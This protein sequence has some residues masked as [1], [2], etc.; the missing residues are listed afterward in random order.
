MQRE[1]P[2]ADAAQSPVDGFLDE[3][4][5]IG[6]GILYK[7]QPLGKRLLLCQLVVGDQTGQQGKTRSLDEF[8]L[9]AGPLF[10]LAPGVR[11][12]IEEGEA[13]RIANGPAIKIPAPAVHLRGR[14]ESRLID[15]AGQH[16]RFVPATF[17][18]VRSELVIPPQALCHLPHRPHR[19]PKR[20][21]SRDRKP[22]HPIPNL[23][24][25]NAFEGV[26]DGIDVVT[27]R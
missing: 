9:P 15:K 11:R 12:A 26:D 24:R 1:T 3:V 2:F 20:L 25:G 16:S 27:D 19:N 13:S 18:K 7:D 14:D 22:R 21:I 23:F 10:D 4:P 6:G 17:P 8:P 5:L